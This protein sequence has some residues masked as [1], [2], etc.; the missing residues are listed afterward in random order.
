MPN[1]AI[2]VSNTATLIIAKND[3]RIHLM[4]Q[5]LGSQSV[6]LGDAST[7]TTATGVKWANTNTLFELS[8]NAGPF[9][10]YYRGD[11]YGIVVS[12]TADVRV[13]EFI[14]TK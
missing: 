11:I 14:D 5:N 10:F 13:W 3:V 6:Y 4:L 9:Q 7:V 8:H 2:S 1:T 12:G